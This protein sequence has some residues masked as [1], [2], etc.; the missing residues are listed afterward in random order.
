MTK[1]HKQFYY[2]QN[3]IL[4]VSESI[5]LR[6]NLYLESSCDLVAWFQF[7]YRQDELGDEEISY[8][9]I[10]E[11]HEDFIKSDTYSYLNK[12]EKS[13]YI[14]VKFFEFIKTNIFFK[15]YYIEFRK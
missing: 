15:K 11:L 8:L 3:S 14:K 10:S 13:K 2:E 6:T 1:Y 12:S 4:Q 7:E 9:R 5:K